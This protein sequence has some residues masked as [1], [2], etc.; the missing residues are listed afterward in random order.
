ML[1]AWFKAAKCIVLNPAPSLL[2]QARVKN[3]GCSRAPLLLKQPAALLQKQHRCE[4]RSSPPPCS[5]RQR[6]SRADPYK[7]SSW[8]STTPSSRAAMY[9]Y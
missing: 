7:S 4:A 2:L 3:H 8:T 1:D 6:S 9:E 5:E